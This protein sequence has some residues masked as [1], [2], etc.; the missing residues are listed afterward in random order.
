[1]RRKI[2][3]ESLMVE[4][5]VN[6]KIMINNLNISDRTIRSEIRLINKD[7]E[8]NGFM[9]LNRR[10]KGYYLEINDEEKFNKYIKKVNSISESSSTLGLE[11]RVRKILEILLITNDY[12]TIDSIAGK[13]EYSRSTIIKD[14]EIVEK[15]L[16]ILKL[17]LEKKTSL[18]LRIAS[19]EIL[20]R[21]AL[22]IYLYSNN[23]DLISQS[24]KDA[25]FFLQVKKIFIEELVE[26]K[27]NISNLAI[28]NIFY[29]LKILILRIN[30]KNFI[31]KDSSNKD[32]DYKFEKISIKIFDLISEEFNITIPKREVD[33][34]A[35]QILYK[36]NI[37][38][39]NSE[40]KK[41]AMEDI[42]EIL[43]NID[44]ISYTSFSHDIELK[45]NLLMHLCSLI[46][47]ARSDTQ[48]KNPY[49]DEVNTRYS[50]IVSI[51]VNFT[52]MFCERWNIK[53]LR[54]EI[55]FIAI[56]FATHFEKA[57]LRAVKDIKRIA[58]ICPSEGGMAYLLKLKL[59]ESFA[60]TVINSYT[61]FQIDEVLKD[62]YDFIITNMDISQ[63]VNIPLFKMKNLFDDHEL[64]IIVKK[65][66]GA[67]SGED[68]LG[69][70]KLDNI[71]FQRKH[72]GDNIDYKNF[73]MEESK[74]LIKLN[75]V[76]K[77][78]EELVLRR[79]E[80]LS[81]AYQNN[82]AGPHAMEM[83]AYRNALSITVFENPIDWKEKKVTIVCLIAMK[84]GS[85]NLHRIIANKLFD[86]INNEKVRVE[87][88]NCKNKEDFIKCLKNL[89]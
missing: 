32:M 3:L 5:N 44:E 7:G 53:L 77:G 20:I 27:I 67:V 88:I 55:A 47:R 73:L 18:G 14:L 6:M 2:I 40:I 59:E 46:S 24:K 16:G 57:R 1:M 80:S 63:K 23:I 50:A 60:N 37:A 15:R 25:E 36:S 54:D 35:S 39:E 81:T 87:I 85:L 48:L 79:E 72:G 74:K 19:D 11:E 33:Y 12:I 71:F 66:E 43:K 45:N 78:F 56:H 84:K 29:H 65:I 17:K 10:G 28:E 34:L 26:N 76:P 86:V 52:D 9:I 51:V 58:I 68:F 22:S 89:G 70:E 38:V 30:S 64:E 75:I 8:K 21:K 82:V 62:E 42:D 83:N 69:K 13:L 49:F 31:E 41:K 4:E 61:N